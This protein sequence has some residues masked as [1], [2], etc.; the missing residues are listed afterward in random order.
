MG[1]RTSGVAWSPTDLGA[2][3]LAWWSADRADL[4]TLSGAQVTSWKDSVAAYDAV[5]AVSGSRPLYSA[6]GWNSVSAAVTFDGIDDELTFPSTPFPLLTSGN[7]FYGVVDQASLV[8]DT[9]VRAMIGYGSGTTNSSRVFYRSVVSSQNRVTT[10][11]TGVSANL[12]AD[13]S[14]RH[15]VRG[16][17]TATGVSAGMDGTT[18]SPSAVVPDTTSTRTRIG[19]NP[20]NTAIQFWKGAIRHLII[21]GPLD[22]G[23]VSNMWAWGAQQKGS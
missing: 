6:T 15:V 12:A 13:F 5:Q 22:A 11:A 18:G 10:Y 7:E 20:A 23:Q 1:P 21:T 3:L 2:S 8:A 4:I 9:N 19:A 16:I 17:V 14:G